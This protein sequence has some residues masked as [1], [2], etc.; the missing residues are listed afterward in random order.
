VRKRY[1]LGAALTALALVFAAVAIASPQLKQT[2]K[3]KYTKNKGKKSSGISTTLETQDPGAQPP[4]N[5]PPVDKVT[6]K[7]KG[8]RVDYKGW[9]VCSAAQAQ[10]ANCP[11]NTNIGS[12]TA[13]ANLVG[14]NP[15]TGQTTVSPL[16]TLNVTAFNGKGRIYLVIKQTGTVLKP[17]L[18]KKGTL[19]TDVKGDTP[20]LPGGN[21]VVLT[22]FQLKTKPKSRKIKG[23]RHILIRTPK[24]PKSKTWKISTKFEYSDG[25]TKSIPITQKCKRK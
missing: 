1:L 24:C 25:T 20:P 18:S 2:A 12:G 15:N 10:A 11:S 6:I 13:Q 22:K 8:A 5:I 9:R 14:T 16:G 4:G 21:K 3:V 19:V 7:F 17:K 23:K